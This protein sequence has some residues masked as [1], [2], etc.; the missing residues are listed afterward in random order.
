[1]LVAFEQFKAKDLRA[2]VLRSA[3][4]EKVWSAG[5]D[6]RE[7]PK[8]DT[9]PL[10]YNDPLEQLLRAVKAFLVHVLARMARVLGRLP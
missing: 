10:P 2:V 1:M 5:H 4:S 9:D 7:L 6:V 8:A 3:V